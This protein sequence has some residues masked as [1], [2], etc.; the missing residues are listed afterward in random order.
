MFKP[1][2]FKDHVR[3]YSDNIR[4]WNCC[5]MTKVGIVQ[6]RSACAQDASATSDA[7][8][9]GVVVVALALRSRGPGFDSR[10]G[11][12]VLILSGNGDLG[13]GY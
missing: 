10:P 12:L 2:Y 8:S 6:R 9:R 1:H 3:N 11:D 4:I 7:G 5:V 13:L